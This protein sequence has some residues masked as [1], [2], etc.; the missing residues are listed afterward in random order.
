MESYFSGDWVVIWPIIQAATKAL[1]RLNRSL[2]RVF[3]FSYK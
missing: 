1:I 3:T 2:D